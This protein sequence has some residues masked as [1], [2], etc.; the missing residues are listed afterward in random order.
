[1]CLQQVP[2]VFESAKGVFGVANSR[3]ESEAT[4]LKMAAMAGRKLGFFRTAARELRREASETA[5]G[6]WI[7]LDR[8]A[9]AS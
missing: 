9:P 3:G 6:I 8:G 7:D 2:T 1:M 5:K 4:R